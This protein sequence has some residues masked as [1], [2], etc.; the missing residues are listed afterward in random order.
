ML[1]L[2]VL[3]VISFFFQYISFEVSIYK[4]QCI[5]FQIEIVIHQ[6]KQI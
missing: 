3:K 6:Q 5:S 2:T 4:F 1:F